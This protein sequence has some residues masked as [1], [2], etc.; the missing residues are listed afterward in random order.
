ARR[1][2]VSLLALGVAL[3]MAA[4]ASATMPAAS[5]SFLGLGATLGGCTFPL[6]N[7]EPP[8]CITTGDPPDSEGA[9]GPNDYFEIVNGG[10][11]IFGK[12]GTMTQSPRFTNTLWTGY[13][14]ADGNDCANENDGD[15]M[16]R[17]DWMADRWIVEQFDLHNLNG[18]S[19]ECVAV[20]K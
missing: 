5:V 8:D 10:Y 7:S 2:L 11:A 16:V 13:S 9:V 1:W 17:Y 4:P 18:P 15:P 20:S 12:T 19:Y 14:T 6:S 3:L